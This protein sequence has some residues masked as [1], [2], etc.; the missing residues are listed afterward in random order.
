MVKETCAHGNL[1]FRFVKTFQGH[2]E[3]SVDGNVGI[4]IEVYS[5]LVLAFGFLGCIPLKKLKGET[6]R[7]FTMFDLCSCF[8]HWVRDL[9]VTDY[10][11]FYL[12]Y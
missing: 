5:R 7:V 10:S 1:C 3:S 8:H 12:N 11:I 2:V 4:G 9:P 6:S